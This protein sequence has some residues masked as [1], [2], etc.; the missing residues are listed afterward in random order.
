MYE[1]SINGWAVIHSRSDE[2]LKTL[3]IPG[4]RLRLTM[5]QE[6]VAMFC[7]LAADYNNEV[8]KLRAGECGAYT[9][10]KSRLAE[11]WSDHSSGTAV[12]LNWNHEGAMGPNGG[13][14]TMSDKQIAACAQIKKRYR[15]VVWGGDKA[16]GGDYRQPQNWDPMHYALKPGT[17]VDDVRKVM[18]RLNIN[19]KG[20]RVPKDETPKN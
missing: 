6:I 11:A 8:A 7:A 17:T 19:D 18:E 16:R 10:R 2:R 9:Y 12:D 20:V 5:R 1:K 14:K 15:V 4:T 3:T 13:M